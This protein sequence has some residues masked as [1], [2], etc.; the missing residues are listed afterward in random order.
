M[1]PQL[2]NENLSKSLTTLFLIVC[3]W[4]YISICFGYFL[5]KLFY[6]FFD[7]IN[8]TS[9]Y[10]IINYILKFKYNFRLL[11]NLLPIFWQTFQIVPSL[12]NEVLFVNNIIKFV[13]KCKRFILLIMS[14]YVLIT[15]VV[16]VLY[17]ILLGLFGVLL[18]FSLGVYRR[19]KKIYVFTSLLSLKM[20]YSIRLDYV[21]FEPNKAEQFSKFSLK[22]IEQINTRSLKIILKE[23]NQ[24]P[25][26]P[27]PILSDPFVWIDIDFIW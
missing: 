4:F 14:Q 12:V 6:N 7:K 22:T 21:L 27:L 16:Y 9:L 8:K 25:Q 19:D 11:K 15:R 18:G 20:L 24:R 23:P 17:L 3:S 10:K 13:I 1:K 5:S 2:K 26:I